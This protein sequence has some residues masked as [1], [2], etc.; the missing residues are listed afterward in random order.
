MGGG[1][2]GIQASLDIADQ[3]FKVFLVER[4]PS[5]GGHMA[6]LDKTF[7]TND[8][9]ICIEAPKMVDILRHPNI[10][11]LAYSEVK[12]VKRTDRNFTVRI[13][14]K[15]RYVKEDKC[16]ACGECEKVCIVK[17]PSE[18]NMGLAPRKAIYRPFDQAVPNVFTVDMESC[19]KFGGGCRDCIAVCEKEGPKAV[20]FWQREE[21]IEIRVGS[22]IVATGYKLLV[23]GEK[24]GYGIQKNV[25]LSLQYERL[26]S[27]SGPTG[28]QIIRPSDGKPIKKIAWI[29]CVF[30]RSMKEGKSYCSKIC[31]MYAAKQSILTKEHDSTAEAY[32]FYI[33]RRAYGK[34]Y[35]EYRKRAEE[36]YK[37]KYIQSI[38]GEVLEDEKTGDLLIRYENIE[39]NAI[40]TLRADLLVLCP[41]IVPNDGNTELAEILGIKLDEDGF[42]KAVDPLKP[43]ETNVEGI[44]LCG[45]CQ[46][47]IDISD[48]VA[49]ASAAAARAVIPL[50]STRG[51][52]IK[53]IELPP[54]IKAKL[55]EKPR[56]G[57][58]ICQCGVNIGSVVGVSDVVKYAKMLP[59]VIHAEEGQFIC[60]V[61]YQDI[62]K[63]AIKDYNL[64]RVVAAACTPRTHEYLFRNTLR[65]AG[66]NPYLF[67]FANIR[68][69]CSWV[70]KDE[71]DAATRKAKDL[72]AMAVAKAQLLQPQK[73]NKLCV[74]K[75]CLV[76]GGGISGIIAALT[77]AELGFRVY[78]V[79]REDELGGMLRRL[80]R[81]FPYDVP[82]EDFL[83]K[84]LQLLYNQKNIEV[85]TGSNIEDIEGYI[86]NYIVTISQNAQHKEFNVSTIIIATGH[87]EHEAK[88]YYGFG[89]YENVITQLQLE[90]LL[91]NND[92]D[93]INSFVMINCVGARGEN[94]ITGCC[95]IGC[96]TAIKNARY[97]KEISPNAK[98]YIL[99]Q[100]V[101][102]GGKDEKFY[103]DIL[104]NYD[105]T[106]VRYGERKPQVYSQNGNAVV[107]V[108]DIFLDNE[109]ELQPDLIVLTMATEGSE[110]AEKLAKQ[111][112]IPI[113][114]N[115]YFQEAHMKLRPL[116]FATDG[117]YL[118]GCAQAPKGVADTIAQALGADM[119]AS[120]PM[121]TGFVVSEGITAFISEQK[122][123]SCQICIKSCPYGAVVLER[124]QLG[125]SKRVVTEALCKGCGI[126]AADCPNDAII[127]KHFT[128]EQILAQV[129]AA[130]QDSPEEK[131]IAFC[132]NWCAYAGADLAGVS[133]MQYPHCI[134]I[135][136]VMCSGRV[137]VQFVSEAFELGAGAVAVIGCH[138]Q[139]CHYISGTDSAIKR[140]DRWIKKKNIDD[141]RFRFEFVSASEGEKFANLANELAE[142]IQIK[143]A[144]E[145]NEK[146]KEVD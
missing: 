40:K 110:G 28:G 63:A 105:I 35:E 111:L 82:A 11:L 53:E 61:D 117:I 146:A 108:Y 109:I 122:C 129:R 123:K 143:S 24:Y 86:G 93:K 41:A 101:V 15:P 89:K 87:K 95:R 81:L 68:E 25:L 32:I 36:R 4:T 98:S 134:R 136:R 72:V 54:E 65:D 131:I 74:G 64:T 42:I 116:D 8:C 18:F 22:I 29:Q 83:N 85:F 7:P 39:M 69:Q 38:P 55:T 120:I 52:E 79:E 102:I 10:K 78:L 67:E 43:F 20:D 34:G 1:I 6:Q 49:Q 112:K 104:E 135:I 92:L 144:K 132:C 107:K 45:T 73:E 13:L 37:V 137:D 142:I 56:I 103:R 9:S 139:D 130:L 77:S 26:L 80:H 3:G 88:G 59:N 30:S 14:K 23:P 99:C 126:C 58:F 16:N 141:S 94:G 62:I 90:N 91:K 121:A 19:K 66:L 127:M 70:H 48:T 113:G 17:V 145:N 60:S 100:D 50:K 5:I 31:C 114:A 128:D 138:P 118:C 51:V 97:I 76:I 106:F 133:R 125:R 96:G 140:F 71:P 46:G 75:E 44:Y 12:E 2:A 119:R 115:S 47:P 84:W 124:P 57:V 33:D 27:A 21:M